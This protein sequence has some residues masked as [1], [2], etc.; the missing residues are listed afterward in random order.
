MKTECQAKSGHARKTFEVVKSFN[1][2]DLKRDVLGH[3]LTSILSPQSKSYSTG[4]D[5]KALVAVKKSEI[6]P[7]DIIPKITVSNTEKS[8]VDEKDVT[9]QHLLKL[10]EHFTTI[11]NSA[12]HKM[13]ELQ[14]ELKKMD[15][16]ANEFDILVEFLSS[17]PNEKLS[18]FEQHLERLQKTIELAEDK[19]QAINTNNQKLNR[20]IQ[21]INENAKTQNECNEKAMNAIELR[22][23]SWESALNRMDK[24][25]SNQKI[26]IAALKTKSGDYGQLKVD[27]EGILNRRLDELNTNM[28]LMKNIVAG[29]IAFV[30]MKM[31]LFDLI[32]KNESVMHNN[33]NEN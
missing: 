5:C 25:I 27:I 19:M 33:S 12:N 23:E 29:I 9:N 10:R 1:E 3:N 31:V 17:N 6:G 4:A 2:K 28:E 13:L 32:F 8:G 21:Q 24:N 22:I 7:E 16:M 30:I 11:H 26:S 14:S 20:M 15:G 18:T